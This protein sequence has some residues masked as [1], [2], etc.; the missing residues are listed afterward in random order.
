[1]ISL[2]SKY[3]NY[4]LYGGYGRAI[5]VVPFLHRIGQIIVVVQTKSSKS[6][7]SDQVGHHP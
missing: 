4:A 5:L 2:L 3:D 6:T 7:I 1:M